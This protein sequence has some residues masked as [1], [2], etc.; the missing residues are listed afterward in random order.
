MFNIFIYASEEKG[1]KPIGWYKSSI[2]PVAGC[3]LYLI[4]CL[5]PG[6][7]PRTIDGLITSVTQVVE[8]KKW[9][10]KAEAFQVHL[11]VTTNERT[12]AD[13]RDYIPQDKPQWWQRL[14][15][16]GALNG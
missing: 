7:T 14:F 13:E 1:A 6:D 2:L 12:K 11:S 9:K 15:P 10:V 8:F 5:G 3:R 4:G 16:L